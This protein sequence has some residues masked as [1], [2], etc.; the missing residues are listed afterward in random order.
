MV[1]KKKKKGARKLPFSGKQKKEQLKARKAKK[2]AQHN[3]IGA[4]T[5]IGIV[6][7]EEDETLK[8]QRILGQSRATTDAGEMDLG[9]YLVR[10]SDDA[11]EKR[12][13]EG[14]EPLRVL[15]K[16]P[17]ISSIRQWL[18]YPQR[19]PGPFSI[20]PAAL[21]S[22]ERTYLKEYIESI[23]KQ[24][25][26][27]D[28]SVH[29]S[30]FERNLEVWRQLWRSFERAH[31]VIVIADVRDPAFHISLPLLK[32]CAENKKPVIVVLTK[33]DLVP[34]TI[35]AKWR[36]WLKTL[37]AVSEVVSFKVPNRFSVGDEKTVGRRSKL[38]KKR[39]KVDPKANENV[40]LHIFQLC[41]GGKPDDNHINVALLGQPSVGKSSVMNVLV[42]TKVAGVSRT[43]GKTKHLQS[44]VVKSLMLPMDIVLWD[45]PGLLFPALS[46]DSN[47]YKLEITGVLPIAQIREAY[48]VVRWA[49]ET[50]GLD[51]ARMYNLN[52]FRDQIGMDRKEEWSP[53]TICE[54][55]ATKRGWMLSRGGR[56]DVHRAGL[57]IVKDLVDGVLPW[58]LLPPENDYNG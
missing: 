10:E 54:A 29:L 34:D 52:G 46:K 50:A 20:S 22:R 18:P 25:K 6:K 17:M 26:G 23:Q 35:T 43:P 45:C 27:N 3:E 21:D 49:W 53:Y 33:I 56:A 42:G 32:S 14:Y 57:A 12:K 16:T 47:R 15:A 19:P 8:V 2:R 37:P 11:V 13:K 44:I 58:S 7:E 48:T 51:L 1:R 24:V 38:L 31:V 4:A 40:A 39:T 28:M 9:S 5:D 55:L 36:R 30:P 41:M